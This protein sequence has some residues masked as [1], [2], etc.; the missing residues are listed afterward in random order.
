MLFRRKGSMLA[1]VIAVAIAVLVIVINNVTFVGAANGI[2]RDLTDY[3]YGNIQITDKN[4]P[5]NK[6]DSEIIGFLHNTGLVQGA[7]VRLE[8]SASINNTRTAIPVKDY[9]VRLIG[10]SAPDEAHASKILDTIKQGTFITSPDSI[11]LGVNVA[12]DLDAR[13]GDPLD[14]K[15]TDSHGNDVVKRFFVVGLSQSAG[16]FGID[17]AAVVNIKTLRDMT[18]RPNQSSDVIVRLY[19]INQKDQ[20]VREFAA[21]FPNDQFKAQTVQEA[22]RGILQGVASVNAFINIVGY[23]GMLSSAF[24]IITIMMM[25][26]SSKLREIGIMR[27]M[28]SNK[29]DIMAIFLLQGII[30]GAMGALLGFALASGYTIYSSASRLSIGGGI[31]LDVRYDPYAT[32]QTA[33]TGFFMAIVASLYPAWRTTKLQ[34]SEATR[35]N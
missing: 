11:V 9:G 26:V 13:I 16:G 22:A 4:G 28:G 2:T 7:A 19:D 5:I 6:P 1:A 25:I 24:G 23:F 15:V 27:A 34:P 31:A 21:R 18:D 33:A 17:S 20:L 12:R 30:I 29:A 10:M 3:Q 35:Y 14:V 32:A 8:E